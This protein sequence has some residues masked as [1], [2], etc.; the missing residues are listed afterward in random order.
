MGDG[1]FETFEL[2]QG[3][4]YQVVK[5]DDYCRI[6]AKVEKGIHSNLWMSNLV[7]VLGVGSVA[8]ILNNTSQDMLQFQTEKVWRKLRD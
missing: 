1:G 5:Y 4:R 3:T 8:N 2:G 7:S 6:Y